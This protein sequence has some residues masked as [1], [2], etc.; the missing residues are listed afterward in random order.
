MYA[1]AAHSGQTKMTVGKIGK[2][3]TKKPIHKQERKEQYK[4]STVQKS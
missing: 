1:E 3:K 4:A 2:T